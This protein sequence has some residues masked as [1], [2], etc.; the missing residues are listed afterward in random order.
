MGGDTRKYEGSCHIF[1]FWRR[2]NAGQG[3]VMFGLCPC[4][5]TTG[6]QALGWKPLY[7]TRTTADCKT[8]RRNIDPVDLKYHGFVLELQFYPP[9]Q[10]HC[11]YC[12]SF[13][14]EARSRTCHVPPYNRYLSCRLPTVVVAHHH[15]RAITT[16]MIVVVAIEKK[17][18]R[19]SERQSR[20][21]VR[22]L[23]AL[24]LSK[25]LFASLLSKAW[26]PLDDSESTFPN[27]S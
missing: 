20:T 22:L 6:W 27:V 5:S 18:I 17:R 3:R 21:F 23:F 24:L 8:A 10:A 26:I 2:K 13:A 4:I 19:K 25:L 11:C 14:Q 15:Y 1:Y 16:I 12:F 9:S 7:L